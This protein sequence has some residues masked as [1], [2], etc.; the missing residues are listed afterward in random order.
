MKP[1]LAKSRSCP[2]CGPRPPPRKLAKLFSP[3]KVN[4]LQKTQEI[5]ARLNAP[6]CHWGLNSATTP[7]PTL[8]EIVSHLDEHFDDFEQLIPHQLTEETANVSPEE[9]T[10][11]A[12]RL[13]KQPP[14]VASIIW[15]RHPNSSIASVDR[16][17]LAIK[18]RHTDPRAVPRAPGH[19]AP[20]L[21]N[22]PCEIHD[23]VSRQHPMS[24]LRDAISRQTPDPIT[25]EAPPPDKWANIPRSRS[26]YA[27]LLQ[28]FE[29]SR[30]S[31]SLELSVPR[32]IGVLDSAKEV[33]R[34]MSREVPFVFVDTPGAARVLAD[35][36]ASLHGQAVA[37]SAL[38]ATCDILL[39]AAEDCDFA[40]DCLELHD[41]LCHFARFLKNGH[42]LK[43]LYDA[44]LE[45]GAIRYR[46]GAEP[47]SVFDVLEA[48]ERLMIDRPFQR[49]FGVDGGPLV[50]D[51]ALSQTQGFSSNRFAA[52][53]D[54]WDIRPVDMRR[55]Q[56]FR[57]RRVLLLLELWP[58]LWRCSSVEEPNATGR[59]KSLP[60]V[61]H[62]GADGV[63]RRKSFQDMYRPPSTPPPGLMG[64]TAATP[65]PVSVAPAKFIPVDKYRKLLGLRASLSQELGILPSA[66]FSD[67]LL[68]SI[69]RDPPTNICGLRA[70][71]PFGNPPFAFGLARDLFALLKTPTPT[72]E[73]G[74]SSFKS[75]EQLFKALRWGTYAGRE[76][77]EFTFP[78]F[79]LFG[80][81]PAPQHMIFPTAWSGV[82]SSS[83][84]DSKLD[85]ASPSVVPSPT[86]L[87]GS[88]YP[89]SQ[90]EI[91]QQSLVNRS[92]KL[93]RKKSGR[94]APEASA[95]APA[96]ARPPAAARDP[97][98]FSAFNVLEQL[99]MANVAAEKRSALEAIPVL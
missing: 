10:V 19:G 97:V 87:P 13:A 70:L 60:I 98:A 84:P 85:N 74:I 52:E 61:E 76:A 89:S 21:C 91:Y 39:I 38:G 83:A 17:T 62:T 90:K 81:P 4:S 1:P 11:W 73:S 6:L 94:A 15:S 29:E 35:Y 65:R 57:E 40:V 68:Q 22:L 43:V 20:G 12:R 46:F 31:S 71:D 80:S 48:S 49:I 75:G 32:F 3:Q 50:P 26:Y 5:W 69:A 95:A 88:S 96:D 25:R 42:V 8:T 54:D 33:Y 14:R 37:L 79:G 78:D 47:E 7:I 30:R 86:F 18:T 99:G 44:P 72:D 2:V 63:P 16:S 23:R 55:L 45:A 67:S 82:T 27:S 24:V 9:A 66:L 64:S 34:R 77:H 92:K 41:S 93:Q 58:V 36:L 51:S 56:K 28:A 59:P 53:D